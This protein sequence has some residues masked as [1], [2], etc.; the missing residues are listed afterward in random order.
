M[1]T[2]NAGFLRIA[3]NRLDKQCTWCGA[4][5]PKGRRTWC[6]DKC[7][8]AFNL[9]TDPVVQRREL[10]KRDGLICAI[11]DRD[12]KAAMDRY[13]EETGQHVHDN[14]P[15]LWSTPADPQQYGIGRGCWYE[16]DHIVPVCEFGGLCGL[17]N[18]RLICGACHAAET[19]R[20]AKRRG[21]RSRSVSSVGST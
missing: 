15:R 10:I 4:E 13:A 18:L 20:L 1:R 21:N 2:I 5:V 7:V 6:S 16:V 9:R 3:L 17:E 14:W 8:G 11:C 12:I 19:K